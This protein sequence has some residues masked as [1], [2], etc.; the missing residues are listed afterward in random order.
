MADVTDRDAIG[1]LYGQI[2]QEHGGVDRDVFKFVG[3]HIA[4][5]RQ[6]AESF[7]V[8]KRSGQGEIGHGAGGAGELG[9]E[10]G[11]AAGQEGD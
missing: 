2:A 3:D 8:V 11:D 1:K 9:V 7:G 5:F 6:T 4:G 10:H